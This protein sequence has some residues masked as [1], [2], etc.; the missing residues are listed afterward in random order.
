M[1]ALALIVISA[2]DVT[3]MP[4]FP[5]GRDGAQPEPGAKGAAIEALKLSGH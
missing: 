2:K 5:E 1:P 4:L 3:N